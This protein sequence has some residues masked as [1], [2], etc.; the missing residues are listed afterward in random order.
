MAGLRARLFAAYEAGEVAMRKLLL[1]LMA[2]ATMAVS[3]AQAVI[4]QIDF[5]VP[6][7]GDPMLAVGT[8][9]IDNPFDVDSLNSLIGLTASG[10]NFDVDGFVTF[11]YDAAADW[12]QLGGSVNGTGGIFINTNDFMIQIEDFLTSPVVVSTFVV[13]TGQGFIA[14]QPASVTVGVPNISIPLPGTVWL[15]LTLAAALVFFRRTEQ[16]GQ[17]PLSARYLTR[18]VVKTEDW[19]GTPVCRSIRFD[20]LRI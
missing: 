19:V 20:K 4:L 7:T 5:S 3:P 16:K 10:F 15:F 17:S 14:N 9:V 12:L 18:L 2:L 13:Q 1:T 11:T 6:T 8:V